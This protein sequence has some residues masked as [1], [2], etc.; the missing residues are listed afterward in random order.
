MFLATLI[1]LLLGVV[2]SA[3]AVLWFLYRN[4]QRKL[5]SANAETQLLGKKW[6]AAEARVDEL[7]AE[8]DGLDAHIRQLQRWW[9][10]E[11]GQKY[12]LEGV[13]KDLSQRH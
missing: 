9:M 11:M 7:V 1:G 12:K 3:T 13:L 5:A 4:T 10:N 2:S 6:R 8:K